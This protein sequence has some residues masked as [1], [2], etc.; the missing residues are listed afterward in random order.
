VTA[1]GALVV[2]LTFLFGFGNAWILGLKLGVPPYV[3]PLVAPAVDLSVVGL[4]LAL[5]G[6]ASAGGTD[7]EVRSARGLLM[8]ASGV[9]LAL[10]VAPPVLAGL[11]GRAAF[12]AVGPLLLIGWSHVGPELLRALAGDVEREPAGM[13]RGNRSRQPGRLPVA[14]RGGSRDTGD[15]VARWAA[16]RA[17]AVEVDRAHWRDRG[18]PVSAERLRRELGVASGTARALVRE[19]R[20]GTVPRA[21]P[22][23]PSAPG[24]A[25]DAA[26]DADSD[27]LVV[28]EP[29][30]PAPVEVMSA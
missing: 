11:W 6:L 26:D 4:L 8:F 10:N 1:I 29:A 27:R 28:L 24:T 25:P 17:R 15:G 16:L 23:G 3:A 21:A 19:L 18:R 20:T 12:D 13:V 22:H 14:R 5:R 9:T 7:R 2:G 30:P